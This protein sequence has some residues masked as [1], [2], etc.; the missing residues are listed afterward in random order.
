MGHGIGAVWGVSEGSGTRFRRHSHTLIPTEP[1]QIVHVEPSQSL[2]DGLWVKFRVLG[3]A[4]GVKASLP[5]VM[6]CGLYSCLLYQDP[7]GFVQEYTGQFVCLVP[8][9]PG[10]RHIVVCA[11]TVVSHFNLWH[12]WQ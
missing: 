6:W 11:N 4:R 1:V 10:L 8:V 5:N 9:L 12:E 2:E 7:S 3:F